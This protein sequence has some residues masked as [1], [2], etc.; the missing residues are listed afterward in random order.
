MAPRAAR[1]GELGRSAAT[2]IMP[3]QKRDT[4]TDRRRNLMMFAGAAVSL[5]GAAAL[6]FF[7]STLAFFIFLLVGIVC[8]WW[9]FFSPRF[10]CCPQCG[11]R[12][13]FL[14]PAEHGVPINYLCRSCDVEWDTGLIMDYDEYASAPGTPSKVDAPIPD[15]VLT[16]IKEALFQNRRVDAIKQFRASTGATLSEAVYRIR[17]MEDELRHESPDKFSGPTRRNANDVA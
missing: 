16:S 2:R 11:K 13:R 14:P 3:T 10:Y 12:L 5:A 15:E 8:F 4:K 17:R 7:G 1:A 6:H 9:V